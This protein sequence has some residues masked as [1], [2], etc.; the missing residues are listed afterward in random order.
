[1]RKI[2]LDTNFLLIPGQFKIDI[3]SEIRRICDF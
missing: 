1:M 3:F 2:I